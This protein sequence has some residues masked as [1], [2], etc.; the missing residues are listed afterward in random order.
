MKNA[1]TS[2]RRIKT[3]GFTSAVGLHDFVLLFLDWGNIFIVL[4]SNPFGFLESKHLNTTQISPASKW[5]HDLQ[6]L[7][8]SLHAVIML[9]THQG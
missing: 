3:T 1:K 5:E 6:K 7:D 8:K 4:L 2:E 9:S